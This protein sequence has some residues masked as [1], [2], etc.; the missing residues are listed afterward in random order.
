M[1]NDTVKKILIVSFSL[2]I[3]CSVLVSG[4][5]IFLKERQ[6][7]N[8]K[9]D[10]KR[11]LLISSGAIK[12]DV[13]SEEVI[14]NAYKS[15]TELAV[16]LSSGE[17]I[18]DYDVENLDA[19]K[20]AKVPGKN[21][22][23][24]SSADIAKIKSISKVSKVYLVK[25]DRNEVEKIVLPVYG[26]GLWSTMYGFLALSPDTKTVKGLG[27]YEHGETPGLG[28]E[29]DNPNWKKQWANKVVL[30]EKYVPQIA[31]VKGQVDHSKQSNNNKVDGLSGATITSNGVQA[32]V[33]FWVSE[34][35]FG[36]FL[37]KYRQG[38]VL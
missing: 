12:A 11:N 4:S 13:K 22:I 9:L 17:V 18:R 38:E 34:N 3:F 15:V 5:A 6:D 31:V 21:I 2:S 16:D 14:L 32:L 23:L 26:K 1:G 35:G 20:L 27:F 7:L 28:G 25:N 19:K 8:K 36:P 33:N 24:S 29:I 30:S 37:S 10:V